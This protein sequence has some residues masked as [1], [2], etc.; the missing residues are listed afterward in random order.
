MKM[1]CRVLKVDYQ[2]SKVMLTHKQ[3]L[4]KHKY[5]VITDYS[6]L[7]FGMELEGYIVAVKENVVVV[8]FF[9]DVKGIVTLK[10][11]STE[12]VED[13]C[14]MFYT[15]QV[16][17]C[18]VV[19]YSVDEKRLKLSLN[20]G[21]K[22]TSEVEKKT[23]SDAVANYKVGKA[24]EV[25]VLKIEKEGYKVLIEPKNGVAFL[26]FNHLS[27]FH[28]VQ[29]LRK[30][31]IKPGQHFDKVIYFNQRHKTIVTMK[32]SFIQAAGDNS[33][34]DNFEDLKTG[35]LL[36]AVIKN[37]QDYGMFLELAAGHTGLCPAKTLTYLQPSNLQVLFQPGQ[38]VITRLTKI[39]T[40]KKR[41]LGS[42]RL[43][44]CSLE[45]INASL[46][47][48]KAYLSARDK[49]LDLVF[50]EHDELSI[51][52]G[53]VAGDVVDVTVSSALKKGILGDL[54]SGAK[55]LATKVNLGDTEP[56]VGRKYKAV[57]LFVDL[58]T[59]CVELSLDQKLVKAV[60]SR[61]ENIKN[62][63][64]DGQ[65]LKA[66]V[67]LVKPEFMLMSL[68]GH[69]TGQFIYVPVRQ[70]L[71]DVEVDRPYEPGTFTEVVVKS[72]FE[73]YHLAVL[74]SRDPEVI[75]KERIE[76][77]NLK[78]MP[79]HNLT[80]GVIVDAKIRAIHPLQV[81][82][83]VNNL[84]GRVHITEIADII[85]EGGYPLHK[86]RQQQEL[87]VK[88]IGL[89]DLKT[90]SYLP[91]THPKS[92]R[93]LLECTLKESKITSVETSNLL[94]PRLPVKNGDKVLAYVIKT[95]INKVWFQVSL[96]QQGYIDLFHLSDDLTVL[97][98]VSNTFKPGQAYHVTVLECDNDDNLVLSRVGNIMKVGAGE[99]VT[100]QITSIKPGVCL[101]VRLPAGK[102]GIIKTK[103]SVLHYMGQFIRCQIT[104]VEE[105]GRCV[106]TLL[107]QSQA[108]ALRTRKRRL[109]ISVSNTE[110]KEK[111]IIKMKKILKLKKKKNKAEEAEEDSGVDISKDS[112]KDDTQGVTKGKKDSDTP[113]LSLQAF[114]WEGDLPVRLDD[115]KVD[116][117]DD[118]DDSAKVDTAK[119]KKKR[120][121]DEEKNIQ[122][123]ERSQ[124]DGSTNAQSANDFERLVLQSPNSSVVWLRYLA[125]HIEQGEIEKARAVAEKAL[126]TI[127]FREEQE[128]KNMWLAYLNMETIYGEATDVKKLLA[129]AV[130]YNDALDIN[131]KMCD[132]YVAAGKIDD[133]ELLFAIMTRKY[134][135]EKTVWKSYGQ[136]LFKSGRAQ[137]ARN[138]LQRC[139]F[140][141]DKKDHVEVIAKFANLEFTD[142]DKERGRTMFEN[143]IAS[144]PSR[145]DL[146]SVYVDMV[147]K[148]G[149]I[150]GARQILERAVKQKLTPKKL[151]FL[152]QKY[153]RFEEIHG[154]EDQVVR[155][156]D[157]ALTL[158]ES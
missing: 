94:T 97:N 46:S 113:R 96:M 14:T 142:G 144:Y 49:M 90:F 148:V 43:D 45:G 132:I 93:T 140:V 68:R 136:F 55:A 92:N 54:P 89:R 149:D 73:G 129:R 150:D 153:I 53:L 146:W 125:F 126:N 50:V 105:S 75:E 21:S 104:D 108:P 64:K 47:L 88:V 81:N 152:I 11:M 28:E 106:L 31:A 32:E 112:D 154:S 131:L 7:Q 76:K 86:I 128:K 133:A 39:D 3:S 147:A 84:H 5:P 87:K 83:I 155:V 120:R 8:A 4:V 69:G 18:R 38:T 44:E 91:I 56:E 29:E 51:Y 20:F 24:V 103:P 156:K 102:L 116:S 13:P 48:L 37:H 61:K 1:K 118:A 110:D 99:S 27:D 130:N 59:P 123:Y 158:L 117:D 115:V 114:S 67:L 135:K 30:L 95:S 58:L 42:V 9:N 57:V 101:Y 78:N 66:D 124:L 16:I 63:V 34:V 138:L 82:I 134:K 52:E 100:A 111:E 23:F 119:L 139:T 107:D 41:F 85:E 122:E 25:R 33:L 12:R 80:P 157:M 10:D 19:R 62:K 2:K 17:R 145:T 77:I 151:S 70:H 74:K 26:P 15:G 72:S 137:T 40:E 6:Q 121:R 143:L 22:K 71:N 141:L 98:D 36:P 79:K 60:T 35:M 127:S 65:I 109:E